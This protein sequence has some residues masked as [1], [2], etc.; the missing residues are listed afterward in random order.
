MVAALGEHPHPAPKKCLSLVAEVARGPLEVPSARR[1]KEAV[2][3]AHSWGD[4]LRKALPS[5]R[6][7]PARSELPPLADLALL[8]TAAA[9]LPVQP[10]DLGTL[11]KAVEETQAWAMR[12]QTLLAMDPP[13][14]LDQAEEL[15][16]EG[17]DLPTHCPEVDALDEAV[18]VAKSWAEDAMAADNGNA[19][20]GALRELLEAGEA[21]PVGTAQ[22]HMLRARIRVREWADVARNVALGKPN[23]SPLS[24]VRQSV[25][26]GA[27][28]IE[29]SAGAASAKAGRPA[30]TAAPGP[31]VAAA[32]KSVDAKFVTD[33]ERSLLERLRVNVGNGEAG[34]SLRT[35]TRPTSNLL[36]LLRASG[37]ALTL[38][39]N[40]TPISV[41]MLVRNDPAARRG[42]RRRRR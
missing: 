4:K 31:P 6:H 39:V 30:K 33:F 16:E 18:Q 27:A 17:L 11:D 10:N 35:S 37:R 3:A 8:R 38:K 36:V 19:A 40:H 1:L 24:E 2:A 32:A 21:M 25:A 34:R 13:C 42:R 7:R 28:I 14:E 22:M 23:P 12:A 20:T 29:G 41:R 9:H 15:L 26:A 5:R